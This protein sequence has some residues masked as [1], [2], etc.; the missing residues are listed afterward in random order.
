MDIF[1]YGSLFRGVSDIIVSRQRSLETDSVKIAIVADTREFLR[2]LLFSTAGSILFSF[3]K[4]LSNTIA[5]TIH[6]EKNNRQ[7]F[8][9]LKISKSI[10]KISHCS[11]PRTYVVLRHSN[12]GRKKPTMT[13]AAT[14]ENTCMQKNKYISADF[15]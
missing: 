1:R 4:K 2:G 5:N 7:H 8:S 6:V 9:L 12:R 14:G 13:Q 15:H 3:R 11:P 10:L